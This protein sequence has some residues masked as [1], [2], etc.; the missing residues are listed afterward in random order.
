GEPDGEGEELPHA[1][2]ASPGL[3]RDAHR[4]EQVL[5]GQLQCPLRSSAALR[6]TAARVLGDLRDHRVEFRRVEGG[7]T[8]IGALQSHGS[9]TGGSDVFGDGRGQRASR[10]PGIASTSP[11][12]YS[13]R[14]SPS[15]S[16]TA[17]DSTTAPARSTV[18][19]SANTPTTPRSWVT[20]R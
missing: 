1:V 8:A 7:R 6:A 15:T 4:A 5:A 20:N 9:A 19:V 14:G 3:R 13:W 12:V 10:V 2:A 17:P 11:R 16:A 18:T